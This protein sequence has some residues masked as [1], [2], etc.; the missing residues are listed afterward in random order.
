MT[1]KQPLKLRNVN[2]PRIKVT[3]TQDIIDTACVADSGHCMI[4]DA[5]RLA[6]PWALRVQSDLQTVRMTD[7]PRGLRYF[8]LTPMKAKLG[9]IAF[10]QGRKPKAFTFW[11]RT[12]HVGTARR[13]VPL[14][15]GEKKYVRVHRLGKRRLVADP[16]ASDRNK[17]HVP[18]TVGGQ[19]APGLTSAPLRSGGRSHRR[20]SNKRAFGLRLYVDGFGLFDAPKVDMP[21]GGPSISD[22]D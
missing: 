17:A 14:T 15:T 6:A 7:E 8:Y 13:Q 20:S 4:S 3:V 11:L 19:A 21:V 10:D 12:A 22:S 5:V 1:E 18:N 9:L 16:A 2:A